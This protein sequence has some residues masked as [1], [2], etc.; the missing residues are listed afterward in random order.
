LQNVIQ[1][2][3]VS[4]N[5][6]GSFQDIK[7]FTEIVGLVKRLEDVGVECKVGPSCQIQ[8]LIGYTHLLVVCG[9]G[10][11]ND[12]VGVV[13]DFE[14]V[15]VLFIIFNYFFYSLLTHEFIEPVAKEGE[16]SL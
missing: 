15:K 5:L 12:E 10:P 11:I 7:V 6:T 4:F 9:L 1:T 3:I 2:E 13:M 16:F 14:I 8:I